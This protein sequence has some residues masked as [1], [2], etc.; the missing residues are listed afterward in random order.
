MFLPAVF[1]SAFPCP[2]A[3]LRAVGINDGEADTALGVS[4]SYPLILVHTYEE[5]QFRIG[6]ILSKIEGGT[7]Y[8]WLCNPEMVAETPE[9][10]RLA[11]VDDFLRGMLDGEDSGEPPTISVFQLPQEG[12]FHVCH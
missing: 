9:E 3:A 4:T 7:I 5:L 2:R 6:I 1:V 10:A 8:L 12:A 11:F